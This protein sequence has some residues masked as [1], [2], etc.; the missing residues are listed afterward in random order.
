MDR[1]LFPLKPILI[2]DDE[3]NFLRMSGIALASEGINN[4]VMCNDSRKALKHLQEKSYSIVALDINMPFVSGI[5]LLRII[6]KE[7]PET[8][9]IMIT[10]IEDIKTVVECIRA[11]AFDYIVKPVRKD[12]LALAF[13]KL[14]DFQE[15]RSEANSLKDTVLSSEL[16]NPDAF[17]EII[18]CSDQMI[19]IFRYTEV[20]A[21][22]RLP[23][24]ITGETGTGKELMA[25]AIH[26][27]S[28]RAGKL[29]TINVAGVDD[30]MFSDTLFGH[31]KGAFSGADSERRGLIEEASDGT[32]F[33]DEIG[34]LSPESQ[35][36]L[37]RL[38]QDGSYYPLGSDVSKRST[39][40]VVAATNKSLEHLKKDGSFR[41]DLFYRLESHSISLPPLRERKGDISLLV[42]T[43]IGQSARDM[44]K[45]EPTY[46]PELIPLLECYNF[47]GN[48]RELQ[49]MI[50]DA[51]SLHRSGV[52]S[53][54]SIR[55]KIGSKIQ[56]RMQT[57]LQLESSVN[58]VFPETLPTLDQVQKALI[59]EA[60]KR[61]KGNKT[62]AAQMLGLTR[63]TLNNWIRRP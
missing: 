46:P 52:M 59:E 50:F 20:I 1:A 23:V 16:K 15:F 32:L 22:T 48:I 30:T 62:L 10:G 36:K 25:K 35:V 60:L 45:K 12:E 58:L 47:P 39:A 14:L 33:L 31:R 29:V 5:E 18:T 21:D 24:L 40:R 8:G 9:I 2:V 42:D 51:V 55:A 34:D 17:K 41:K 38:L 27:L 13:R 4:I 49:G 56:D 44:N 26:T 53:L 43:F 57:D 54:E 7:Y 61:A 3:E 6:S 19:N 28:G 11:G 37:L 63:Q